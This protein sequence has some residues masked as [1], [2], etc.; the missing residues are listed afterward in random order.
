MSQNTNLVYQPSDKPPLKKNLVY[1]LQQL[2]A[3]MAATLLVPVLVNGNALKDYGVTFAY[4]DQ[5]AALCGAG[6]GTLF[7]LF[8]TQRKSPV[9]LGS[10]F[11]FIAPLS[12]AAAFGFAGIFLGAVIA[13]LVYL[14]IAMVITKTG[15]S[16]CLMKYL[17]LYSRG[18]IPSISAIWQRCVST[19]KMVCGAPKPRKAQLGK[20][21]VA[22]PSPTLLML[23]KL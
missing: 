12:G 10:S 6:F 2:L 21:F 14:I 18:S 15:I 5:A 8:M 16:P 3:I 22:T 19:A 13:G 23:G 17:L 4:L 11:A 1:A 7:Y 20:V 9:F